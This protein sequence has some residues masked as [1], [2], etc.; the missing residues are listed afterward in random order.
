MKISNL[1]PWARRSAGLSLAALAGSSAL[2]HRAHADDRSWPSPTPPIHPPAEEIL[3]VDNPGSTVTAI[4]QIKYA[5]PSRKFTWVIPVPGKPTLG[6]S[7]N[8]VLERLD[9]ATAPQYWVEVAVEGTC[10]HP[11]PLDTAVPSPPDAA[12]QGSPV[13]AAA[14]P[15]D[16]AM[17]GPP[18]AGLD[19][20]SGPGGAPGA[21]DTTAAPGVSEAWAPGGPAKG[22]AS[23]PGVQVIDRGSVGPYDYVNLRVDPALGDP[24]KVATDWLAASGYDVAGLDRGAL[25]RRVREG[26]HLLALKLSSDADVGAIRPVIL[27]YESKL[28]TVP[29]QPTAAAARG[30]QVWVVGPS[31]AVPDNARSLVL[32]DALLDWPTGRKY[33]SGTLPAGGVGPFDPYYAS[34]PGNYDAVVNTAAREA[35]GPG[36]VTELGAPA[37]EYRGKVWSPRDDQHFAA[38]SSQRYADGIDAILTAS[39]SYRGWDGWKDAI[40]GATTLP[41]GVTIDEFGRNPDRYRGAARVEPA[42]FFQLLDEKVIRPVAD[43]G[44]MLS[45]APY[46]TRLYGV[47][48]PDEIEPAFDY[49]PDLALVSDIHIARQFVECKPML[50]PHDA[51]WRMRLPQGG[52]IAGKG[53]EAW[54]MAAGSMPANLKIVQLTTTGPGAVIQDNSDVIGT[55]MV[56]VAGPT[57]SSTTPDPPQ[58]G[59]MIGGT[60]TVTPTGQSAPTESRPAASTQS[61]PAAPGEGACSVS[62]VGGRAGSAPALCLSQAGLILALRRRRPQRGRS[63]KER[64]VMES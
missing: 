40:E 42:K 30:V 32:N 6:V 50:D 24:A 11:G 15:Q 10:M 8:A 14:G 7:S 18:G 35:G 52:A 12:M 34:K 4:V 25:R 60:Q 17:Q 58:N 9:A 38:M 61:S 55:K 19:A 36:F 16:A 46:L 54:P 59:V 62:R 13:A 51:P 29:M 23:A 63:R 22:P 43:A 2:T 49:N 57:G 41:A 5:G 31:Q 33:V 28:P 37:S 20:G 1:S 27:T 3:L 56:P 26:L 44:A 53:G 39:G 21:Y 47:M 45:R 64:G 48:A